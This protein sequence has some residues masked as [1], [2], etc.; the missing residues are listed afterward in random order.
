MTFACQAEKV[1]RETG[2]PM[3]WTPDSQYNK[4]VSRYN[5]SAVSTKVLGMWRHLFSFN[6][7]TSRQYLH[8]REHIIFLFPVIVHTSLRCNLTRFCLKVVPVRNCRFL[9]GGMGDQTEKQALLQRQEQIKGELGEKQEEIKTIE[10]AKEKVGLS[11]VK[12]TTQYLY[13]YTSPA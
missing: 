9:S 4:I 2:V 3:I 11:P 10:H 6:C 1:F 7:M 13:L 5:K 8:K 12:R